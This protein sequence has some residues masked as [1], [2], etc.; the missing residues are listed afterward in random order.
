MVICCIDIPT[1]NLES[2]ADRH[3]EHVP[4]RTFHLEIVFPVTIQGFSEAFG[5]MEMSAP[6]LGDPCAL[7]IGE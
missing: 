6:Y 4:R 7:V 1:E 5:V 3:T 2:H